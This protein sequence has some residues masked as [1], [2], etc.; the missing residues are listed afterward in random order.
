MSSGDSQSEYLAKY[1]LVLVGKTV[2]SLVAADTLL[3]HGINSFV[4]V[5]DKTDELYSKTEHVVIDLQKHV[6]S[7]TH[8]P[9]ELNQT[10]SHVPNEIVLTDT[11]KGF[12]T[13]GYGRF[14]S[15]HYWAGYKFWLTVDYNDVIRKI[16]DLAENLPNAQNILQL[17]ITDS[18]YLC[19]LDRIT[20]SDFLE[21]ECRFKNTISVLSALIEAF[22]RSDSISTSMLW[23]LWCV[24]LSGG[25]KALANK[26]QICL[27]NDEFIEHLMKK[28]G[29]IKVLDALKYIDLNENG[30]SGG[31]VEVS[32]D[33]KTSFVAE[34]V[35]NFLPFS[36]R[37]S[38]NSDSRMVKMLK[39]L[40]SNSPKVNLTKDSH[41]LT[42]NKSWILGGSSGHF[43][44]VGS[45]ETR[46]FNCP[47]DQIFATIHGSVA[48]RYLASKYS[49][50]KHSPDFMIGYSVTCPKQLISN[51]P[52]LNQLFKSKCI[53]TISPLL[54][55]EF[56]CSLEGE[57]LQLRNVFRRI[58]PSSKMTKSW[59]T[60]VSTSPEASAESDTV[61][62]INIDD[63]FKWLPSIGSVYIAL[64]VYFG[65]CC[66]KQF[67]DE[68]YEIIS[69]LY[70]YYRFDT[71]RDR[72]FEPKTTR[73]Q[74]F[75]TFMQWKR[76]K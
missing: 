9:E 10:E 18:K 3:Q 71:M 51:L 42:L 31:S 4:I 56:P 2:A 72:W 46:V 23:F 17:H 39:E 11:W 1:E 24:K 76:S 64:T 26:S 50:V 63:L 61:M 30:K 35:L 53:Y 38:S 6:L 52:S 67:S 7:A 47:N 22:T 29:D 34:K 12:G 27:S 45:Y 68:A 37:V 66:Y 15:S 16:S 69:L 25:W 13:P 21:S 57:L 59:S 75:I 20:V 58:F 28:L 74:K 8:L 44:N 55:S 14:V 49:R 32:V 41:L 36:P 19:D 60:E 70:L 65:Y 54:A 73:F 33:G 5:N 43:W 62:G 48:L 40:M